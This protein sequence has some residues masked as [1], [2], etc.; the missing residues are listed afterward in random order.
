MRRTPTLLLAGCL[1]AAAC[2]N[3]KPAA[4]ATTVA[5]GKPAAT[6]TAPAD[7]TTF[8]VA[9]SPTATTVPPTVSPAT[10]STATSVSRPPEQSVV[11]LTLPPGSPTYTTNPWVPLPGIS[12]AAGVAYDPAD[13]NNRTTTPQQYQD[14]VDLYRAYFAAYLDAVTH[15]PINAGTTA[16]IAIRHTDRARAALVAEFADYSARNLIVDASGGLTSRPYVI[17]TGNP[18]KVWVADCEVDATF[19]KDNDTGAKAP[20]EPGWPNVGPPGVNFGVPLLYVRAGGEWSIDLDPN[21]GV[22]AACIPR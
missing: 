16:L 2:S 21:E 1:L 3:S 13:P 18:D 22:P 12:L 19:L 5:E 9:S 6:V 11:T 4:V 7:R 17:T 8:T 15:W 20:P 10:S 14:V